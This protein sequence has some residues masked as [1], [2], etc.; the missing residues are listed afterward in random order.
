MRLV[1]LGSFGECSSDRLDSCTANPVLDVNVMRDSLAYRR[2]AHR[3]RRRSE[4][5]EQHGRSILWWELDGRQK[6]GR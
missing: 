5:T 2:Y 6:Y 4:G 3:Y 1:P